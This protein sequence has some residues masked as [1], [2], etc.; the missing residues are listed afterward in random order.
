MENLRPSSSVFWVLAF[1]ILVGASWIRV[2]NAQ[3][4]QFHADEGVQAYQAWRLIES[5]GYRYDPREHHGPTLY[6]LAN[7]AK[8]LIADGKGEISDFRIRLIPLVFG[9]AVVGVGMVALRGL[10]GWTAL[11]WGALAAGAPLAVIYGS[12]FVQESLLAFFTFGLLFAAFRYVE[13]PG[14]GWAVAVGASAGLM[15]ATKET[16]VLHFAALVLALVVA[17]W[18]RPMAWARLWRDVGVAAGVALAIAGLFFTSFGA[19]PGG[20]LDAVTSFFHYTDRAQGQGHEKPFFYYLGL[21]LPHSREGIRWS[22]LALVCAVGLG[23]A[24]RVVGWRRMRAGVS[25]L[26]LGVA[27]FG[28]GLFLVYSIIPYKT[29]WLMLTPYLALLYVAVGGLAECVAR[30]KVAWV[31][32]AVAG[33]LWL[34]VETGRQSRMAVFVYPSAT[35]NPYLYEH[36]TPRYTMLLERI[37]ELRNWTADEDWSLGIYSP[38][39]SWPLPWHLRTMERTGYRDSLDNYVPHAVDAIDTRLLQDRLPEAVEGET[40]ELYGLRP[41]TLISLRISVAPPLMEAEE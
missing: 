1:A 13:R 15:V 30:R 25:P 22:E 11:A 7:W 37:Q 10:G 26:G 27:V 14:T 40:W 33:S 2:H 24:F 3:T 38:D 23:L 17:F 29:P 36:T 21:L 18:R 20:A 39:H 31:V 4:R 28:V 35:R 34:A 19:N 8:P 12:Y 9:V 6:Y 5:E 32:V 41:N 16:A